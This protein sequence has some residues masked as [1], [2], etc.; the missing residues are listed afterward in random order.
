[1]LKSMYRLLFIVLVLN[2]LLALFTPQAA[3]MRSLA[4][5]LAVI[6]IL[7]TLVVRRYRQAG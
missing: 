4:L 6:L 5:T 3:A 1:M 2:L 7:L